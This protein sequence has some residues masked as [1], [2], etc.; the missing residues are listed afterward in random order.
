[1]KHDQ[2]RN[3]N[4]WIAVTGLLMTLLAGGCTATSETTPAAAQENAAARAPAFWHLG[5]VVDDLDTMERFY[6]EVIGLERAT[7]LLLEAPGVSTAREGALVIENLD[8]MVG[9]EDTRIEVRSFSDPQH[10]QFLE[11]LHYPDHPARAVTQ[12]T[13]SPLGFGHLGVSVVAIDSVLE[14]MKELGLGMLLHGPLA[15]AEFGGSRF[16]FLKNPEGNLVEVMERGE[17]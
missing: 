3:N 5:L 16:A 4:N 10:Q 11:L 12:A 8:A 7:P 14:R 17:L 1:M 13:N 9:L 15:V 2:R 6:G